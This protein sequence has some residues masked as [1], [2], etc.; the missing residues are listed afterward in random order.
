MVKLDP[1]SLESAMRKLWPWLLNELVDAFNAKEADH[2][3]QT[4]G[5]KIVELMAQLK[6]IYF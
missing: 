1:E 4:E 5:I 2:L 3:L 6:I